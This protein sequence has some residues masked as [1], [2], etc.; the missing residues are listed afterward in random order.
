MRR[1][2]TSSPLFISMIEIILT[3]IISFAAGGGLVAAIAHKQKQGILQNKKEQKILEQGKIQL[4]NT[5]QELEKQRINKYD[6]LTRLNSEFEEKNRIFSDSLKTTKENFEFQTEQLAKDYQRFQRERE[7]E[8][9]NTLAEYAQKESDAIEEYGNKIKLFNISLAD[10]ESKEKAAVAAKKRAYEKEHQKD[11]YRIMISEEDA[12]EIK[13]LRE[14]ARLFKDGGDALSKVIYK[15]YY[16]KPC[17]DMIGRVVGNNRITGIY[18]ITNIQNGM[19]YVGQS[20]DIG[21]RFKQHIKKGTGADGAVTNKLYTAM[22]ATGIEN[23]TFEIIEECSEEK[24][25]ER[26]QYYQQFFGSRE[27]GYSMR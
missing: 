11:F 12:A 18:K 25:N 27:F 22:L 23:F 9:E 24:L 8:Y 19:T 15:V 2:V 14:T 6:D 5:I 21:S 20:V 3:G 1:R 10:L 16:D 26:E 17:T 7:V 4:I 13:R